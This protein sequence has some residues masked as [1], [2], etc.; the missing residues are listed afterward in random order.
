MIF[1]G[2]IAGFA[3]RPLLDLL[4]WTSRAIAI[5]EAQEAQPK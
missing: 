4:R 3:D 1:G 5:R 2:G